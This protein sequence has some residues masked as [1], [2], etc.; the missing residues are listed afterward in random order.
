MRPG[1][2]HPL[3][4]WAVRDVRRRPLEAALAAGCLMVLTAFAAVALLLT[5]A[6]ADTTRHLLDHSPAMVIRRMDAGTWAPMPIEQA[7]TLTRSV[8]GVLDPGPESGAAP[9]DLRVR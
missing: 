2:N 3:I 7:L 8:A 9:G 4:A 1:F 5:Q 6:L